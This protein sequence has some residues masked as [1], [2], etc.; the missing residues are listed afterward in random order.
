M[1]GF[2]TTTVFTTW[3]GRTPASASSERAPSSIVESAASR[4]GPLSAWKLWAR[5][6]TSA[7][8]ETC[9]LRKV[10]RPIRSPVSR[11]SSA[12]STVV[13]PRSTAIPWA[14]SP[15][16]ASSHRNELP[17]HSASAVQAFSR[18]IAD[19]LSSARGPG[20][21]AW[22]PWLASPACSLSQ[23]ERWSSSDGTGR[24]ISILRKDPLPTAVVMSALRPPS[25]QI[26][27]DSRSS[28][29]ATVQSSSTRVWHAR[30][31]P[32]ALSSSESFPRPEVGGGSMVTRHL[33]Q[34]PLPPQG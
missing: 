29:M 20:V 30:R 23:S 1:I 4:T 12:I 6:M 16:R 27:F 26:L 9:L 13:V 19:S 7:P 8:K 24:A 22:M 5:E 18:R 14:C 11:S 34:V 21:T 2:P 28:G 33:R 3:P 15:R 10:R 25:D 32:P 31:T 17:S